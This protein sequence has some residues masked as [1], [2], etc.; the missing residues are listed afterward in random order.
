MWTVRH[1]V[2]RTGK[3]LARKEV[4]VSQEAVRKIEVEK[5]RVCVEMTRQEVRGSPDI[6]T[7]M[8]LSRRKE[9]ELF[10]HYGWIP[11]WYPP[12]T[13]MFGAP[14]VYPASSSDEMEK[15]QEIYGKR[16]LTFA[17]RLR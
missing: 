7:H 5:D 8:P 16:I 6:D 13:A 17:I 10:G 14:G 1:L 9:R 15:L 4:L 11:Y 12:V 2:V 3:F